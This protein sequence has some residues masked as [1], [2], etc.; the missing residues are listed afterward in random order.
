MEIID[1]QVL[2][3]P[4]YWSNFRRKLI[5]LKLD[6]KE[7]EE[8]PS[9]LLKGFGTQL[10]K[11]MPSL[12]KHCCSEGVEGGF[13]L[14]VK[15]GTWIGHI[16]EHIALELQNL[17]GMDCGFGRTFGTDTR[18]VYHVIFTYE[19]EKAGLYAAEAAINIATC[20]AQ[21]GKYKKLRNDLKILKNFHQ[22]A[23]LG[24]STHAIVEEA[25]K[26]KIPVSIFPETSLIVLGYGRHQ[27]KIW[28]NT[29]STTSCVGVEIAANKNM[30]KE[31]LYSN[32]IPVPYGKLIRSLLELEEAI[33]TIGFPVVIKP[34]NG[35]HGRGI[36]TNIIN[37]EK[38]F[39]GF[40]LAKKI[41]DEV[42]I[43]KFVEGDDYRFLVVNYKMVAAAKRTPAHVVGTGQHTIQELINQI[44]SDPKRGVGHENYLTTIK[45]DAI[46]HAI[47]QQKNLTLQ[48]ILPANEILYLKDSA[49]LSA[50]GT[51][52]DVTHLVH[53]HNIKLAERVARLINLDVCGIDIV[54][55]EVN[56]PITDQTG[57]IIEVNA[58]P[59]LR[60]HLAP[61]QGK[62]RKV[63]EPILD[64]LYPKKA[65]SRIPII[66]VTGTNGKTTV[67]RLIA[68]LA[69][70]I[71]GH[72]VGF[73]TTEG[74]YLNEELIYQGDC[75]G[76][77]SAKAILQEPNVDFAVL[78]CARGGILRS[79]LAFDEC[80]MSIITNISNDHLGLNDI[81]SI[82][83]LRDVKGVVAHATA[84]DGYAILN[85]DDDLVYQLTENLTCNIALFSIQEK[86][87]R[88]LKHCQNGG[89]AA[90]IENGFVVL[91]KNKEKHYLGNI[92]DFPIT[93]QGSAICMVKNILPAILASVASNFDLNEIQSTL[94]DFQP[95]I[96]DNPGRMNLIDL[97]FCQIIVDYAHNESAFEDLKQC[98]EQN[99]LKKKIGI[100]AAVGDRR[101]NDSRQLGYHAAQM[102]DEII[103]RHNASKRG[104]SNQELT[105]LILEGIKESK[106][107]PIVKVI[108][109]EIQAI[110]HVIKHL[111]PDTLVYWS[112]DSVPIAIDYIKNMEK[113]TNFNQIRNSWNATQRQ[114]TN[115]WRC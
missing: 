113:K 114:S 84:K 100:I 80:D 36:T 76:P 15:D 7:Y 112:V 86:N 39:L 83:D 87:P 90:Y 101:E 42:I 9:N 59:G 50:G 97:D 98:I 61:S 26:R 51:A 11:L 4:N 75:S 109:D 41:S 108:S 49:N 17:A 35:N 79:G 105:N 71:G 82:E 95:S 23:S 63:A 77:E 13:F 55:K 31:V 57:A 24:P 3:G 93:L 40:A 99:S 102:F 89:L 60:M 68:R 107:K 8:L 62:S 64:M 10:K 67:V 37:L 103:I 48:D 12:Q 22:A 2:N 21:G 38:A 53:P 85:A 94:N 28:A 69:K 14:R 6:I 30:T 96:E 66:G 46:T 18:G 43:E 19:V 115:H 70:K 106:L 81:H 33:E 52:V 47:L 58:S 27:K 29:A 78:E 25:K 54:A 56:E 20:L 111:E 91:S 104:R 44:N 5:V 74:I 34:K 72:S 110:Q 73:T 88:V 92:K 1:I 65:P 45:I 16:I 32:F